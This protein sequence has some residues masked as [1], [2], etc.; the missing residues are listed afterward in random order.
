MI[1]DMRSKKMMY[2]LYVNMGDTMIFALFFPSVKRN[3]PV[4]IY[5]P[6]GPG[7]SGVGQ[8]LQT[9]SPYIYTDNGI[10]RN[11]GA[12]DL[13]QVFNLLYLDIPANTGYSISKKAN[14]QYGDEQTVKDA[15][16][17]IN[18]VLRAN[19]NYVGNNP[20]LSF[21]GFSY[22]GKIWPLIAEALLKQGHKIGGLAL[23]SGY[24][25]PILQEIRPLMEYLLYGGLIT[26]SDYKR[27]EDNTN[28]IERM[29][30]QGGDW[31]KIQELYIDTVS[32]AWEI[33]SAETYDIKIPST[34]EDPLDKN[35][36]DI[37]SLLNTKDV[38][39][40]MGVST[41]YN[42]EA[43]SFGLQEYK[44]FLTSSIQSLKFLADNGVLIIY[45]MG[46]LDG[47]T[48]AKGTRDMLEKA[49]N[50]K[51]QE[52]RWFVSVDDYNILIGKIATIKPNVIY[53]TVIGS[54]HS[55]DTDQGYLAFADV[56]HRLYDAS[57]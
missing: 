54:G 26:S 42:S 52:N 4:L 38:K 28:M 55:L 10:E 53:G 20:V 37:D 40:A 2:P 9:F 17:A 41:T 6:G 25:D 44:G 30:L 5:N 18:A 47:A 15:V 13:T 16:F 45:I 33:A 57:K 31:K 46:T 34:V 51:L 23:F 39:N 12:N 36:V 21:F 50:I 22:A 43:S 14:I 32:E 7:G 35:Q 1:T 56:M 27:L 11:S 24:T 48:L 8:I 19:S 3:A 29:L 49:F